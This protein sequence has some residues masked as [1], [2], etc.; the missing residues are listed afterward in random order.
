VS[1]P[2]AD[3]MLHLIKAEPTLLPTAP[4]DDLGR[5]I[6]HRAHDEIHECLRCGL[7]AQIAL[8]AHLDSG[9]RWL[10]LCH[11]CYAWLVTN[12][13]VGLEP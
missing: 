8:V 3:G 1:D 10:D 7:R 11:Q 4:E 12:M 6:E 13:R 9:N 5:A 2:K